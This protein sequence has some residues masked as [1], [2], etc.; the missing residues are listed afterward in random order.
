MAA[1]HELFQESFEHQRG[2]PRPDTE[3]SQAKHPAELVKTGPPCL[4][5]VAPAWLEGELL[6]VTTVSTNLAIVVQPADPD[7]APLSRQGIDD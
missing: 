5:T 2:D 7:P 3:V 6:L 4:T 1:R